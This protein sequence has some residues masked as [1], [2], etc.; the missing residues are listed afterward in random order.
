MLTPDDRSQNY[1]RAS[2]LSFGVIPSLTLAIKELEAAQELDPNIE[3]SAAAEALHSHPFLVSNRV[4]SDDIARVVARMTGIPVRN[5]MRGERERLLTIEDTLRKRV[6]GQEDALTSIADA[7]RLSRAG[8]ASS[9]FELLTKRGADHFL[10]SVTPP[11]QPIASFLAVGPT[12]VGKT[13]L[14]KALSEFLFDTEKALIQINSE[15]AFCRRTTSWLSFS[16]VSEYMEK[17]TVTRL[18]GAP[19]SYVGYDDPGQLS[20]QVRRKP[21]AV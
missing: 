14:A 11:T 4:T 8:S 15:H 9:S 3:G 13:E 7:V 6:V 16:T 1:T 19:P 5:L 12:G 18:I 10:A 20:E 17:H 2:E 21:F